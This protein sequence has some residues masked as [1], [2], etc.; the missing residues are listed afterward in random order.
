M[1]IQIYH[2]DNG[3]FRANRW[4]QVFQH[5]QQKLE[6]SGVNTH[7]TNYLVEKRSRNLQDLTHRELM[8]AV[9]KRKNFITSYLWPYTMR[10]IYETLNNLP[11]PQDT[12]RRT[13]QQI[14]SKTNININVKYFKPFECSVY[15][16]DSSLQQNNPHH[17]CKERA[18]VGIHLDKSSQHGRN[19][20]L[21]LNPTAGLVSP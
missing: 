21:V 20:S 3:I 8:F 19:L 10:L 5:D 16:L 9:T 11:S 1:K 2:T 15:V 6:F 4:Q 13:P 17:K 7:H 14:F 18:K 12:V